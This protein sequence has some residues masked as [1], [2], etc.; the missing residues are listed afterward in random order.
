MWGALRTVLHTYTPI[1]GMMRKRMFR[2]AYGLASA[3]VLLCAASAGFAATGTPVQWSVGVG[4][5]GHYYLVVKDDGADW[6]DARAAAYGMSYNDL[7][8]YLVTL[9]SAA[10]DLFVRGLIQTFQAE[11][12]DV[13]ADLLWLGGYQEIGTP[14][15]Y[16]DWQWVTPEA[17]TYANWHAG[18]PNDNPAHPNQPYG[19]TQDF[20]HYY[21]GQWDDR[22]N[23]EGRFD[24][25][26]IEFGD[27][28]DTEVP[29]GPAVPAPGPGWLLVWGLVGL[30]GVRRRTAF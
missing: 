29:V 14:E 4:G 16:G 21:E 17:W 11:N 22:F 3:L 9:T 6:F 18:E 26:V 15:P 5:N 2:I 25:Y 19:Y 20:L 24:G 30:A 13:D 1:E 23:I 12:P 7:G 10:E 8:G 28:T 27:Y